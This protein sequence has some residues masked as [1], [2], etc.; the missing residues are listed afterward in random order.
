MTV[1]RPLMYVVISGVRK[2][3]SMRG[4]RASVAERPRGGWAALLFGGIGRD[5]IG[6]EP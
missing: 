5:M 2:V 3:V 4:V 6:V 1:F